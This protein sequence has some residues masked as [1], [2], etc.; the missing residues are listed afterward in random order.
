MNPAAF[1]SSRASLDHPLSRRAFLGSA[2]GVLAGGMAGLDFLGSPALANQLQKD[3]KRAI[4]IFLAG[5]A[6]QFETWDPKPRQPTGG[7][8]QA[9]QTSVPGVHLS[10]LMPEMAKRLHKHTAIIR[11]L[12][13]R[14]TEH[15]GPLAEAVLSGQRSDVG[16]LRT[17]SLGCML[18]RELSRPDS[19]LPPQHRPDHDWRAQ[20]QRHQ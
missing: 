4:L 13:T 3:Q 17:P 12:S 1:L 5:G 6:S 15:T 7:P 9:I 11:S 10:E 8:F 14:S 19:Q 2:A 20:G 16:K 18:A